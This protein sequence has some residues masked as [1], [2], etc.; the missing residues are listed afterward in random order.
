MPLRKS[1]GALERHA[2]GRPARRS[3]GVLVAA[4][5]DDRG[6]AARERPKLA[7]GAGAWVAKPEAGISLNGCWK[8]KK[9]GRGILSR[10]RRLS[11][12]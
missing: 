8:Q 11:P 4:P 3:V 5:P 7:A 10:L 12:S 9:D 2:E 1:G 6:K